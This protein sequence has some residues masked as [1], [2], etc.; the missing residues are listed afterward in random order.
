MP[1]RYFDWRAWSKKP[2][3][4]LPLQPTPDEAKV[5]SAWEMTPAAWFALTNVQRA[6]ARYNYTKAPRY[7]G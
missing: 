4:D 5:I 6:Y 3:V 7:V 2:E 1:K